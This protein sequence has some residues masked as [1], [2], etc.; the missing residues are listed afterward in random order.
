M[1]LQFCFRPRPGA[2]AP[3]PAVLWG[4]YPSGG[5]VVAACGG[6][7]CPPI[8]WQQARELNSPCH[9][10]CVPAVLQYSGTLTPSGA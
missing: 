4:H 1:C 9:L 8:G 2:G 3:I 7:C 10:V 5:P 6:G